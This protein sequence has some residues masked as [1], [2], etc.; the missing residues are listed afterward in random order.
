MDPSK[1]AIECRHVSL[2]MKFTQVNQPHANQT[3]VWRTTMAANE[4]Y[5]I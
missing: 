1:K 5:L 3:A 2:Y 4:N